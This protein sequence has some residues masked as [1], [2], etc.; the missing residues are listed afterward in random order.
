MFGKMIWLSEFRRSGFKCEDLIPLRFCLQKLND[1][2]LELSNKTCLKCKCQS[3]QITMR[4]EKMLQLIES[5]FF[6]NWILS[7]ETI[8]SI[9]LAK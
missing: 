5:A 6:E 1:R 8:N 7:I 3:K 9:F 4:K 2:T